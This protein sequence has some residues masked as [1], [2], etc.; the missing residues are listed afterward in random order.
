[1]SFHNYLPNYHSAL[2]PGWGARHRGRRASLRAVKRPPGLE[3]LEDRKLPSFIAPVDYTVA[4]SPIGMKAGDFNGDGIPDL[5]TANPGRS[6][7]ALLS[8]GDGTFQPARNTTTTYSPSLL[9]A[10]AV[11]D[12]D[13]DGKLD[14][15][16]SAND[17]AG[18]GVNVLL[19]RGDGTFVNT[20]QP[21]LGSSW[22]SSIA[23]GDMNGDGKLDLVATVDDYFNGT[24]YVHVLWG[25]GD[26]TFSPAYTN[27]YGPPEAYSLALADFDGDNKLDLVLGGSFTTWVLLGYGN[28][29]FQEPRDLGLVA[30]SLTVA[31]FNGDGKPDLASTWGSVN[32][33]LGNGDGSFQAARSFT[34][35]GGSVTAADVNGDRALDLVLGGG[36]VL[37]GT[38]DGN[39]G[40]PITTA[41]VGSYLVIADFNGDGRPDEA[42]T[43]T[44]SARTVTVLFNDG[45]WS[46]DDPP[47]VSIRDVPVTEGNAGTRAATFT[48]TLSAPSS[49]P[50]TV[51]YATANGTAAAGSDYQARSGTLTIPAGQTTGTITVPV[52]GD[53]FPEPNETFFVNLRGETTATIVDGQAVGTIVDDEP[54]ISISDFKKAEG[55]KS[56]T[57]LFT[58]TVTLSVSYDQPVTMSFG[59]V[60]G[61]A[62]TGDNDYVA[63]SGTLTF[64]PGETTKTI[65]IEVKGDSRRESNE[66]FYLDLSSNSGNSLFTKRRGVGTIL[67][68]D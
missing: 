9:N 61:T 21:S 59:T 44:T 27:V 38:G 51:R 65:I 34:A 67:D 64:A 13:R 7:S 36:S 35:A 62:T 49:Q 60:N 55:M 11:G 4:G 40:P 26:G 24:T 6:V 1:M 23:T 3:A 20:V 29:Y 52:S 10:L 43:G 39:F 12:F 48:V 14:L 45:H 68:D 46:P 19:G 50:V 63:K 5:A 66:Y 41:V 47:S 30:E 32:V 2:V 15:A 17:P 58:F 25:R 16:T 54:R 37:L 22:S 28:G 53:R 42:L 57:T 56:R 8:N 18:I 33:L 31:D